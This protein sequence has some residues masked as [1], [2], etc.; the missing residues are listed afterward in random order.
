MSIVRTEI[1]GVALEFTAIEKVSA[2]VLAI[3]TKKNPKIYPRDHEKFAELNRGYQDGR[4]GVVKVS[5]NNKE[6]LPWYSFAL[7]PTFTSVTPDKDYYLFFCPP[8]IIKLEG[9]PSVIETEDKLFET[10][11]KG[12]HNQGECNSNDE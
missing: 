2:C 5:F 9:N 1:Q 10:L 6:E 8:G 12:R 11:A 3:A 4:L 7:K